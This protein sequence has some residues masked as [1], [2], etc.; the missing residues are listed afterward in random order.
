MARPPRVGGKLSR[1]RI[2]GPVYTRQEMNRGPANR[3]Q[4]AGDRPLS[5]AVRRFLN[6]VPTWVLFL[7]AGL[8]TIPSAG[9]V[10]S[11]FRPRLRAGWWTDLGDTSTWS[12]D[13]YRG[14]LSG[15]VN[16]SFVDALFNSLTIAVATT[17]IPLL[18]GAWAAYA[19]AWMPLKRRTG[20]F[21]LLVGLMALPIQVALVPLLQTYSGGAHLTLPLLGKTVTVFPDL[22]LAGELPAVWLTL[23]G[24]SLPFTIFLLTVAMMRLPQGIIDA[25]RSD[26][27][28]HAQVFWKVAVPMTG[29]TLAGVAVLLFLWG[30]N[31]YLVP[32]T[33]I[34]GTNPQAFPTTIGLVAYS[35]PTGGAGIAAAATMHSAVAIAVFL[36]LERQFSQALVMSVEH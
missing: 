33:M 19:I 25:A 24:F 10:V 5:P 20:V 16:N 34:G 2:H 7:I 36:V 32:L 6:A 23:I 11:S 29:A 4:S 13:A 12:L 1:S 31:E 14:A 9:F 30:W 17:A 8:W 3:D 18:F 28:T 21:F 15:S 27:A 26:G 22:N 35:V